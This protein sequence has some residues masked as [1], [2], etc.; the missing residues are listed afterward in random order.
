MEMT[1]GWLARSLAGSDR[2]KLY[3]IE[4]DCGEY[5]FLLDEN[6][7]KLRKNKKHIQVIKKTKECNGIVT[8]TAS[9]HIGGK[10]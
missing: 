1:V 4:Q 8:V 5:V 10:K 9:R 3:V 7:K 6:G 2:G